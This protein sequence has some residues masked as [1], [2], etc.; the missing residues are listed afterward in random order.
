MRTARFTEY[1]DYYRNYEAKIT[2]P[3]TKNFSAKDYAKGR[4]LVD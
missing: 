3:V 4:R 1:P 2:L